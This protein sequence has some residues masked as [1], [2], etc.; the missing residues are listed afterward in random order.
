LAFDVRILR[1]TALQAGNK[2][3]RMRAHGTTTVVA[4]I[5]QP[6]SEETRPDDTTSISL[7]LSFYATTE[8][9]GITT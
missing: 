5:V 3:L 8:P 6:Y 9:L 2:P 4:N 1:P 7:F